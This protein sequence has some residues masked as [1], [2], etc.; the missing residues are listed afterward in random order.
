MQTKGFGDM[1]CDW[2]MKIVRGGRVVVKVNNQIGPYFPTFK[3]V[4]HGEP[5]SPLLFD[6]IADG[7][8][9]LL[10]KAQHN[11]IIRDPMPQLIDGGL[12]IL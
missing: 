2:M 12:A 5:L 7:L 3:G 11:R 8:A 4:R 9:L 10:K 1:W 6:I